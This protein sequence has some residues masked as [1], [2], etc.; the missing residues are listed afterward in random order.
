M[1]EKLIQVERRESVAKITLNRPDKLNALTE[2]MMQDLERS[3][4]E[5]ADSPDISVIV[6]R[7]AGRAFCTG[8]DITPIAGDARSR[9]RREGDIT[10]DRER[11]RRVVDRWLGIWDLRVPV[12][13]QVH[14]QCLAGGSEL[15]LMCD[16]VVMADDAQIGHPAVRAIGVPPTNIYP[17]AFGLRLA[18][19]LV[20][21]G[22]TLSGAEAAAL[23]VANYAVPPED[24]D[25]FVDSLAQRIA[26][27]PKELLGLNKVAVNRAYEVMGIRTGVLLGVDYDAI[28]HFT[29]AAREFWEL[30]EAEGLRAALQ[31]RDTPFNEGDFVRPKRWTK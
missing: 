14:G 11:L 5:L 2:T 25:D 16:L 15:A 21:T 8:Y 19:E 17:Y 29:K 31:R 10:E 12:I 1:A 30:A 3:L 18:K 20:L 28:G 27:T 6:L 4:G 22:D 13:A 23:G 26:Q 24:L 9:T 7:G